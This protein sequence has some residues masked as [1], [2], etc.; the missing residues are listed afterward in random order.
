MLSKI[1]YLV[2]AMSISMILG[3]TQVAFGQSN[4]LNILPAPS[5]FSSVQI[6]PALTL[7]GVLW[8][9][10]PPVAICLLV[11][12]GAHI[13]LRK[14]NPLSE[15]HFWASQS[16]TAWMTVSPFI[17]PLLFPGLTDLTSMMSFFMIVTSYALY[18]FSPRVFPKRL[19]FWA[20]QLE[21]PAIVTVL[22][23]SMILVCLIILAM[24][25]VAVSSLPTLASGF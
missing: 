4:N 10:W 12:A 18:F 6:H 2:G 7:L 24:Y 16:L 5:E 11:V 19:R 25:E 15:L 22:V 1:R 13:R 8:A 21:S 14:L 3:L 23:P 17:V 9:T 20:A